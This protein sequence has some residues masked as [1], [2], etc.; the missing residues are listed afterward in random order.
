WAGEIRNV[1]DTVHIQRPGNITVGN[2]TKFNDITFQQPTATT[3]ALVIDQDQYFAFTV[4]D[5]DA[6]QANIDL[7]DQYTARAAYALA[8]EL[9]QHI[10]GLFTEAGAGDV[11]VTLASDDYYLKLVEAG[12]TLDEKNVPRGGRWHV[13]S[14]AG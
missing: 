7:V 13:T 8:D 11:A 5:L 10:A 12:Q 1:G 9:D 4:D 2:Y 14:P 6:V 3:N